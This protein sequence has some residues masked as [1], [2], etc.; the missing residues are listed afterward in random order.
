MYAGLANGS[1]ASY[2]LKVSEMGQEFNGYESEAQMSTVLCCIYG[3][4]FS[5]DH[6]TS[7]HILCFKKVSLCIAERKSVLRSGTDRM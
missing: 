5:E 6:L 2:D 3:G 7:V 4:I 1:V